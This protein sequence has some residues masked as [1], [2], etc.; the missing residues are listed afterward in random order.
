[1]EKVEIKKKTYYY[2]KRLIKRQN[3]KVGVKVLLRKNGKNYLYIS[4]RIEIPE[5]NRYQ[6]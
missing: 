1:M 5:R 4:N 2:R 6:E 3:R